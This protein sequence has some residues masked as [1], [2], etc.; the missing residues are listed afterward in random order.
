[1]NQFNKIEIEYIQQRA[2]ERITEVFDA[3]GLDYTE[4]HDYIQC[5][6]PVHEGDN[7]R[8]M[9]WAMQTS[10]WR[11]KTKGCEREPITGPSNSIFGL[12][13]GVMSQRHIKPWTFYQAVMFISKVLSLKNIKV[14]SDTEEQIEINKA[15][16]QY[17][18]RVS[19]KVEP[20]GKPLAEAI[21]NLKPDTCYYPQRGVSKDT[22]ARYHIS[23]CDNPRKP[24]YGRAFFPILDSTGKYVM[25]WS[26]RSIWEECSLCK[27]Y[28]KADMQCPEKDDKYKYPKWKHSKGFSS[29]KYLYNYWYSRHFI[30][31]YGTA[32]ICESPGNCWAYDSAGVNN[33]VAIFGLSMSQQQS[34][35]LKQVG[36][37]TLIL[38]FDNDKAGQEAAKKIEEEFNDSFRIFVVTPKNSNDIADM[39]SWEIRDYF[40]PILEKISRKNIL[41]GA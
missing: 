12:I 4:R 34:R 23:Y 5:A 28:H 39:L 16:K 13:R 3:L 21:A 24:Y 2:S 29:R 22:I 9:Y 17:Q 18:K 26:A 33:S 8:A 38:A 14:D 15:I 25:G 41:K 20:K 7:P 11:C 31:K 36:A 1:M 40:I 6:C 35:L 19:N 37:F 30:S 10:H 32:I 27:L